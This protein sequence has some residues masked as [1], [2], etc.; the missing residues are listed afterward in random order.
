[1]N[2]AALVV[3]KNLQSVVGKKEIWK[4]TRVREPKAARIAALPILAKYRAQFEE[5]G[6]RQDPTPGDLHAV[7]WR[8]PNDHHASLARG[9]L[10]QVFRLGR[11]PQ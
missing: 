2:L 5:L 8:P 9:L 4:S 7:I 11:C 3:P 1:M 10:D 6:E